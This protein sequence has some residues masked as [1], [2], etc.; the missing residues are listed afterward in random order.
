MSSNENKEMNFSKRF[1]RIEDEIKAIRSK[2]YQKD[3]FLFFIEWHKYTQDELLNSTHHKR[4]QTIS[5]KIKSDV[6]YQMEAG[7][8]SRNEQ[9]NYQDF[10]YKTEMALHDVN[11]LIEKREPTFWDR[12]FGMLQEFVRKISNTLDISD[13]LTKLPGSIGKTISKFFGKLFLPSPKKNQ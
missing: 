12:A 1:I 6:S 7:N 5:E 13:V 8:F 9:K 3:S 4:I 2:I 11:E 10:K